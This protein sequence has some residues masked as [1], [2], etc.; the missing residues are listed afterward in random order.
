MR[1]A[2]ASG[3]DIKTIRESPWARSIES[4]FIYTKLDVEMR[5]KR[6]S[7]GQGVAMRG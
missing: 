7:N 4:T 2:D 1:D 3:P 6:R 5:G